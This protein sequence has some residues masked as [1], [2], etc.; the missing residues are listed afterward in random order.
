MSDR[1]CFSYPSRLYAAA[2]PGIQNVAQGVAQQVY[3][4]DD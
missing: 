1:I 4:E 2:Q 3:R